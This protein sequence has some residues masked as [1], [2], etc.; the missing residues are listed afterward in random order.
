MNREA[1]ARICH[2]VNKAYCEAIGDDSQPNWEVAPR[3]QQASARNGVQYHLDTPDA[4][5]EHS[6]EEWLREKQ[7]QGWVYGEEKDP[8]A[9]THPCICPFQD[10][11]K[12]QQV[13]DVLFTH[14]VRILKELVEEE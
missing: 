4:K 13:K 6:H 10:L 2:Q 12:E 11:P 9:K 3:W 5:P 7:A 14:V 1:L 8:H